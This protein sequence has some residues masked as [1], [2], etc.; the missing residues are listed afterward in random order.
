MFRAYLEK[1]GLQVQKHQVEGV[2]WCVNNEKRGKQ[3]AGSIVRGGLVADDMG[4]GKTIQ[5]LGVVVSNFVPRT[6]I[7]LPRA[8]LEQWEETITSTLGHMPLVY[9]G[10]G[11]SKITEDV[12]ASRPI[13]ITTYGM[14]TPR[15]NKNLGILH[16]INWD[17]IIFDEAHHLRNKRT[18]MH[19]GA[20]MLKTPIRWLMTGTP[21][22]NKMDD[23][24]GLC[25]VMGIPMDYYTRTAN[26]MPLVRAFVMK[27]TKAQVGLGLS[28]L[29]IKHVKTE[30]DSDKER[31]LAEEIHSLL[32]FS[33][34]SKPP[35]NPGI[36]GESRLPVM[37]RARQMCVYPPLIE[38]HLNLLIASD[39]TKSYQSMREAVHS[40]SKIDK[41]TNTI[42]EKRN[43]NKA[44][45]VFCHFKGEIDVIKKCLVR[46][47]FNVETF[48]GRTNQSK[49]HKILT[50]SCDVLILQIKTGCEGLNLQQF[51]EIYFVSPHWN[52]AVEDQ[53]IARCH[54][55][56]Q[57]ERVDVY[58]F[59][60]CGFDQDDKTQSIDSYAT[61]V[62]EEKRGVMKMIDG[63]DL[64]RVEARAQ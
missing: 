32:N 44:K 57:T 10:H 8:L 34:I 55:Y 4:L 48:D 1:T 39:A 7:V 47:G 63:E 12:L 11:V 21:I 18:R 13:V 35:D 58:R 29:D 20:L 2:D 61:S 62:Q 15:K 60:M 14:I 43:N 23:F 38:K 53:A 5:M 27:R 36:W 3:A 49:R 45:L 16:K 26:L 42:I 59:N 6:L 24:Y 50:G 40:T 31:E 46:H 25:A 37:M 33:N 64:D 56:G 51:S 17:R 22:Q 19:A 52:P 9:H 54:R 28:A 30:W 41:V